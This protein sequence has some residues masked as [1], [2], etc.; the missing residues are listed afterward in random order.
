MKTS[1]DEGEDDQYWGSEGLTH[2]LGVT[3][4]RDSCEQRSLSAHA[5]SRA[6]A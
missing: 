5:Q 1:T 2:S 4:R 3:D 6:V